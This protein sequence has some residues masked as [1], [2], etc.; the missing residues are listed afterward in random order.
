[1]LNQKDK[2]N[3]TTSITF[4]CTEDFKDKTKK[5]AE[6]DIQKTSEYIRALILKDIKEKGLL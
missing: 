2:L 1:M 4:D 6:L 3:K 5:A